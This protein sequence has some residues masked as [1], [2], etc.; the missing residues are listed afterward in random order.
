MY[1]RRKVE[2]MERFK[3][4]LF[5]CCMA[6][7]QWL[8]N[9]C[10]SIDKVFF[11]YSGIPYRWMVIK[12][13]YL[14]LL[15]LLWKFILN[16]VYEIR[17]GGKNHQRG[18]VIFGV[19]F[20]FLMIV[21]II[22]WPGIWSWDDIRTLLEIREYSSFFAWQHVLTG[23]YQDIFLQLIPAPVG[24]IILQ[25]AVIAMIVAFFVVTMETKM[26]VGILSNKIFDIIIKLIPFMLPPVLAYQ[27]S[28]Y[29]M[30]L[31]VYCEMLVI[32]ALIRLCTDE[33]PWSL[34]FIVLFCTI[35]SIVTVWRTESFIYVLIIPFM[36]LFSK[37][38]FMSNRKKAFVIF[39]F[40]AEFV[41]LN[42]WQKKE[43]GDNNYQI[44]S[45]LRPCVVLVRMADTEKNSVEVK[46][47][48]RVIS[49]KT[50]LDNPQVNG[51]DLYWKYGVVN[52]VYSKDDYNAFLGAFLSLAAKYPEVVI[53]ERKALAKQSLG[54][55][56]SN[57]TNI[58][59]S[60][61]LYEKG[62]IFAD[63]A[64]GDKRFGEYPIWPKLRKRFIYLLGCRT[65]TG[66]L[67][68]PVF[69][70]IWNV[71]IPIWI[72]IYA[73]CKLITKKKWMY[74]LIWGA[75]VFRIPIVLLTQPAGWIM[76]LLP[77]YFLGYIYLIYKL[78]LH[79]SKKSLA[80]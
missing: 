16:F 35:S 52:S 33:S 79:F 40:F 19:Y 9:L 31:Y 15:V 41:L 28:G 49:V 61:T 42:S 29:R 22:V 48:E 58:P 6:I 10:F 62:N 14:I 74:L 3:K 2:N 56:F 43:L 37:N 55:S 36:I 68:G 73:G 1:W 24:I 46:N 77:F 59:E 4:A 54:I 7:I 76:Y 63:V 51:E 34:S 23:F 18:L 57:V 8:I 5:P 78:L 11:Q 45:I 67:V 20:C 38:V 60:A 66:E 75:I 21:M 13:T 53:N 39:L 27:F 80:A 64:F 47:L 25:N 26:G 30:G 50:V 17:K 65:S 70:I 71:T 72:L 12:I 44:V 69:R 32:T